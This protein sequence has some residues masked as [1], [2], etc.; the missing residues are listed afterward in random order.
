MLFE[1]GKQIGIL[2]FQGDIRGGNNFC[3]RSYGEIRDSA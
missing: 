2:N 3:R 1:F